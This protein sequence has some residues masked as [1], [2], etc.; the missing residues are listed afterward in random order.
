M[1]CV[2]LGGV[3]L[4]YLV[5]DGGP[6]QQGEEAGGHHG[7]DAEGGRQQDGEPDIWL[8]EGVPGRA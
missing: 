2:I 3:C 5:S 8:A 4:A 6:Q 1:L 7:E